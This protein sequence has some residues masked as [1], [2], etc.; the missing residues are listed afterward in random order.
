M[1]VD[2][3]AESE[4]GGE[5]RRNSPGYLLLTI[6]PTHGRSLS[7]PARLCPTHSARRTVR[8]HG[9]LQIWRQGTANMRRRRLDARRKS[10]TVST[11]YSV[12][13][14]VSSSMQRQSYCLPSPQEHWRAR[15]GKAG[16]PSCARVHA[17]R[18][19]RNAGTLAGLLELGVT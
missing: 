7:N 9:Q 14:Y 8:M 19:R 17:R 3:E 12:L 4:E 6:P 2:Q 13:T 10:T 11:R 16:M 15:D 1:S 5:E 18:I